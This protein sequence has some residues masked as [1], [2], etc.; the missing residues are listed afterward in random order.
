MKHF[1]QS[2]ETPEENLACDEALLDLCEEG[3]GPELLRF[4]EP[5]NYFIVAGYSNK[6][7]TEIRD[8]KS[9]RLNSSH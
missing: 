6:I 4:W 7:Q 5:R 9:T 1:D 8:R 2:F 3:S